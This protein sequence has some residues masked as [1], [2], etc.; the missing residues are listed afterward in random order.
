MNYF[1]VI[2]NKFLKHEE[3]KKN[4]FGC[5]WHIDSKKS[6]Y[7]AIKEIID[8]CN[9]GRFNEYFILEYNLTKEY[10]YSGALLDVSYEQLLLDKDIIKIYKYKDLEKYYMLG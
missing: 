10:S 6:L 5:R 9:L 8:I 7:E 4:L 2:N 3:Y 1:I